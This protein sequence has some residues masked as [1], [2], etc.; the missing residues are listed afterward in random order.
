M[1]TKNIAY[2]WSSRCLQVNIAFYAAQEEGFF[3][4]VFNKQAYE[5]KNNA[6]IW[7]RKGKKITKQYDLDKSRPAAWLQRPAQSKLL[8]QFW[9]L[10]EAKSGSQ[11]FS[12]CSTFTVIFIHHPNYGST[13]L[14]EEAFSFPQVKIIRHYFKK[15]KKPLSSPPL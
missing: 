4:Y 13:T 5:Q 15:W 3:Y 10:Q 11:G 12:R 1:L 2:N 7:I 14:Q 6:Y 8:L 9:K